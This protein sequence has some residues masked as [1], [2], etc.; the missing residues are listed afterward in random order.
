MLDFEEN[1]GYN[2]HNLAGERAYLLSRLCYK[3]F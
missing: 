1:L 2:N 3:E